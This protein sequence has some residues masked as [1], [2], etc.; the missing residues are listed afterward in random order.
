MLT[1]I[2]LMTINNVG[3]D[4]QALWSKHDGTVSEAFILRQQLFHVSVISVFSFFGRLLSGIGSD[5]LVKKL[6]T[7]RFWCFVASGGISAGA[8]IA[9]LA[10]ENPRFLVVVSGLSGLAYGGLFGVSPSLV[11]DT[12]GMNSLAINWGVMTLSPVLF[13]NLFNIC[14][15]YIFDANSTRTDNGDHRCAKGLECYRAA[16][17]VTFA[18]SLVGIAVGL[19]SVR[20]DLQ[21][22]RLETEERRREEE[23]LA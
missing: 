21:R 15:G 23:H 6:H 17:W 8:Q 14:Y 11:A 9:A 22:K 20:H 1:G 16:Y 7:S 10:I 18:A 2:G 13:G 5:L 19:W 12:F 3:N 4:V